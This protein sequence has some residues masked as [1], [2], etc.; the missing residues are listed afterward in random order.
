[1]TIG[2]FDSGIGDLTVIKTIIKQYPN[3]EIYVLSTSSLIAIDYN[4][5]KTIDILKKKLKDDYIEIN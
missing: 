3:N 2:I 1:M 5:E 4:Y